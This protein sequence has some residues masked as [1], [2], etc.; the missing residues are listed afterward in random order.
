MSK[1]LPKLKTL[2][3]PKTCFN[4]EIRHVK[5]VEYF[6]PLEWAEPNNRQ[7]EPINNQKH[8]KDPLEAAD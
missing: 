1:S 6:L 7:N 8:E 3:V 2:T 5:N 4:K